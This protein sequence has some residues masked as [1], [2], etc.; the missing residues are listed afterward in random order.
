M[1]QQ[2]YLLFFALLVAYLTVF[3]QL[4][5]LSFIG[6]DEPRY[7]RIA[8]E[9]LNS[10]NYTTPTLDSFPWLEKPPL[11][12]WLQALSFRLCGVSEGA[13]R[14][15]VAILGILCALCVGGF[16]LA[17]SGTRAGILT[18]LILMSSGLF[19]IF[20]R[21]GTTDMPLTACL[22]LALVCGFRATTSRNLL[23]SLGWG[24]CLGAATLA[25]GPLAL[26]LFGGIFAF[27]FLWVE[28]FGWR[29][30]HLFLGLMT[31]L[32]TAAPWY[33]DVWV[34]NGYHFIVT[35]WINHHLARFM[36]DLHHH[37]QP[38]WF[39]LAVI[40][41]GFFPWIP[42]LGITCSRL[43]RTRGDPELSRSEVFLW[44]WTAI[45]IL[46][47]SLSES[48][49]PGYILPVL[50]P[51]AVFVALEWD[52]WLTGEVSMERSF[53]IVWIVLQG[54]A[55]LMATAIIVAVRTNYASY[56]GLWV[57][58]PLLGGIV[59]GGREARM[60]RKSS[61]F[62]SVVVGMALAGALAFWHLAPVVEDYHSAHK[63]SK[64]ASP[65]L[66]QKRPLILYRYFHHTALYYTQYRSTRE[67][68]P[69]MNSLHEYSARFPQSHYYLLT[70]EAGWTELSVFPE[71]RRLLHKGNL[72]LVRLPWEALSKEPL[73]PMTADSNS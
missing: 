14:L 70:Q 22:S 67:A 16:A 27:Y 48:K 25:K 5:E 71:A 44:I 72:Y 63:L 12:Y 49:L 13:A 11:L 23:W 9:M 32:V 59:W 17:V 65:W 51:L 36:S 64:V 26:V 57:A 73:P 28:T 6:A 8:E 19:F 35:F 4:G 54:L 45:P 29:W 62:L 66:T 15:P 37:S 10:G 68:I 20:A 39:Y 50:P 33:W 46:F 18:F 53:R 1:S 61:A 2:R 52:R 42:F 41:V 56:L 3:F 47:F 40:L 21:A 69:D 7:A 24:F 60:S 31:F 55:L 34:E 58:L 38:V 30:K 43:W